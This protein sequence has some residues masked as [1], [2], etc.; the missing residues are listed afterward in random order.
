MTKH[1]TRYLICHKPGTDPV[2]I[3]FDVS[4]PPDERNHR[5]FCAQDAQDLARVLT[6]VLPAE[7]LAHLRVLLGVEVG[8]DLTTRAF[9][10]LDA[11]E[12]AE[13]MDAGQ[14]AQYA[15][16]VAELLGEEVGA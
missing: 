11:I 7:T 13:G 10:L 1:P 8:I 6:T 14:K 16:L 4:T 12:Q 15:A 5:A 2:T 3:E 9:T